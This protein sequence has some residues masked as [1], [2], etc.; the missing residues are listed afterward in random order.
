[1]KRILLVIVL[2]VIAGLAGI[3]RSHSG[4]RATIAEL[5]GVLSQNSSGEVREEIRKSYELA[6]GARV[7]LSDI[8][9]AISI[10][11][12]DTKTAA[13]Y[14]LRTGGSQ[15]VLNRRK[16]MVEAD[17]NG[18]RIRGAKGDVGFLSSLLGAN[19]SERVTLKLPRQISLLTSG[20][21]GSVIV[22]DLDGSVEIHGINGRVQ[23]AGT[24]G[25]ADFKGVNGNIVVGLKQLNGGGVSIGGVNG[26][27]E[28]RLNEGLNA[29]LETHGMNGRVVSELSEVEIV[30]NRRGSYS[31]RIGNGGSMI[32]A[33]GINGNIRLT[34]ATST[35]SGGAEAGKL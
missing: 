31:A 4:A 6:P 25:S 14:V 30:R 29:D 2:V 20:V 28:L 19:P 27:I 7:E 1:M 12:S 9:G 16:M 33:G 13:V 5:P 3:V 35:S 34:R 15:E 8:N 24:S 17:A 11:T 21:N 22:G 26:S 18:L 32:T 23:I 10:E